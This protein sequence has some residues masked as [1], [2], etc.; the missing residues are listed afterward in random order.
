MTEK[1]FI[2]LMLIVALAC[3]IAYAID[4]IAERRR[5]YHAKRRRN[6]QGI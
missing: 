1:A 5:E 4:V 2:V 6:A 3:G